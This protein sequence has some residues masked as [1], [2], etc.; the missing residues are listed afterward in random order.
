V[1][2]EEIERAV[3]EALKLFRSGAADIA[4]WSGNIAEVRTVTG[5]PLGHG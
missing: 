5:C 4:R 1:S 3:P 2:N